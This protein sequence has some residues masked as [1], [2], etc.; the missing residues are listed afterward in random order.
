MDHSVRTALVCLAVFVSTL[1]SGAPL[2]AQ[3]EPPDE[4]KFVL[5]LER[6]S[7]IARHEEDRLLF[8]YK[9]GD[10]DF[11]ALY[12]A[13]TPEY[14]DGR[15]QLGLLAS[16]SLGRHRI[17]AVVR[18]TDKPQGE[19]SLASIHWET[20]R[21]SGSA[22]GGELTWGRADLGGDGFLVGD[23]EDQMVARAFLKLSGG[24]EFS[25]FGA[26]S[27]TF[28]L[29]R[30]KR[31]LLG[32][33][34][35]LLERLPRTRI[36]GAETLGDLFLDEDRIEDTVGLSVGYRRGA[37]DG[38]F[39]VKGGEQTI[40]GVPEADDIVGFGGELRFAGKS[41]TLTTE[42][43]LRELDSSDGIS[44]FR[45][46]R[47]LLDYSQRIGRF[48]WGLGTYLNGESDTFREIADLYETAG[49]GLTGAFE[50]A[51][52]GWLGCWFMAEEDAPDFQ[53]VTRLAVFYRTDAKEYG[54]GLRREE[55]GRSRFVEDDVGP[56]FFAK[57]D[58]KG[59][60]VDGD[61][62]YIDGD[63]Y[64]KLSIGFRR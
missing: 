43:D 50:L 2:T 17:T 42:L 7:H 40:R 25:V 33:T 13:L 52:G 41:W 1:L 55:T 57:T 9:A 37:L 53:Q 32:G 39:Y 60:A 8:R 56:F 24:L 51:R 31:A 61:V 18:H 10:W 16:G 54:V 34:R 28:D 44:S 36:V 3:T 62:G 58:W 14:R 38:T 22:V 19:D 63:I 6:S 29:M 35:A 5:D 12:A 45:R 59:M 48:E 11:A 21:A 47:L 26:Q 23:D 4:P 64:G 49:G 15:D 46:G 30:G 20:T 27:G